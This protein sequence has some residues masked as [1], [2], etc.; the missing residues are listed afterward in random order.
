MFGETL[1]V[2][3]VTQ[4]VDVLA[5]LGAVPARFSSQ[6][7]QGRRDGFRQGL[8]QQAFDCAMGVAFPD[9]HVTRDEM[10]AVT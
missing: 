8:A 2:E 3:S 1:T 7:E 9:A 10:E 5:A 6:Y 4:A